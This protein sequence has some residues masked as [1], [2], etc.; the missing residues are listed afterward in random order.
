MGISTALYDKL[1]RVIPVDTA[2]ILWLNTHE[3]LPAK[4]VSGAQCRALTAKDMTMLCQIKDFDISE[5]L[6]I[7]FKTYGFDGVGLFLDKK[8]VGIT[9]FSTE[10]LPGEYNRRRA[11]GNGIAIELP[12]GTRCLF[13]SFVLPEHRGQRLHSAMVR[14]AVDHFGKD[15]VTTFV[16]CAEISNQAFLSSVLDQGFERVCKCTE[17]SMLGKSLYKLPKPIDSLSGQLSTDEDG[18]IVLCKAA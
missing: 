6:A 2:D 12:A 9:L 15:T 18:C 13:K 5:Q 7:D 14:F 16:T 10:H 1:K 11:N 17:F 4:P 8:L 3:F